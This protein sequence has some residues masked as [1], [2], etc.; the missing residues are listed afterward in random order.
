LGGKNVIFLRNM[1]LIVELFVHQV[2]C[3]NVGK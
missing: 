1:S 3:I 2:S